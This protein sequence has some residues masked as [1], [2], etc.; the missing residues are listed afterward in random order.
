MLVKPP[1]PVQLY[2]APATLLWAV[3]VAPPVQASELAVAVRSG[4]VLFSVTMKEALAVS[5]PLFTV[6][7]YTPAAF[8][9]GLC[10]EEVKPLGPVQLYRFVVVAVLAV[11][12]TDGLLQVS[13]PSFCAVIHTVMLVGLVADRCSG[14]AADSQPVQMVNKTG[15]IR[16]FICMLDV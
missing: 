6:T 4:A 9:T 10:K 12:I 5:V 3:K 15:K 1:A 13:M 7:V 16:C 2:C 8:T 11:R 14:G